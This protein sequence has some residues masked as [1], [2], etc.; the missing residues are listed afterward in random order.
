MERAVWLGLPKGH[1]VPTPPDQWIL[2][3]PPKD[4]GYI[5]V[6]LRNLQGKL[7]MEAQLQT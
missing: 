7:A 1:P 6:H 5:V 4:H 2:L 3:Q